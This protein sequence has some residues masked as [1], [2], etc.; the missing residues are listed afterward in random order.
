[1]YIYI[2]NSILFINIFY[3]HSTLNMR[4]I[5][6]STHYNHRYKE[7][8]SMI[9]IYIRYL[10][11]IIYIYKLYHIIYNNIKVYIIYNFII[12]LYIIYKYN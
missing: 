8:I 5:Y 9:T 3:F 12:Y 7:F 10:Y 11:Y 4:S 6:F 1:M 2:N